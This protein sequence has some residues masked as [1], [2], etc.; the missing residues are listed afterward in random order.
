MVENDLVPKVGTLAALKSVAEAHYRISVLEWALREQ[1]AAR[2]RSDTPPAP[3]R[4]QFWNAAYEP[5]LRDVKGHVPESG[6]VK[7]LQD[8]LAAAL[9][10]NPY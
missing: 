4:R 5:I 2:P 10:T 7:P 6:Y 8:L 1:M 3:L 9:A